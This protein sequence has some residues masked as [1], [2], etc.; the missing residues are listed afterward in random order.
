MKTIGFFIFVRGLLK[1]L[2]S[3]LP[4]FW[5]ILIM[6]FVLF[7]AGK[8]T[9]ARW[10][11]GFSAIW[12]LLISTPFL[13]KSMLAKLENQ[14]PPIQLSIE[15]THQAYSQDSV[16]HILVLGRGYLTD[17][18]ISYS[19]QL[20]YSGLARLV[21]GIRLY[22]LIP[23]SRLIFSGSAGRQPLPLAKIAAMAA[24]ELGID[25]T[26]IYTI[27]KPWN[28]K[29]EAE[30]YIK[31]FGITS[32]LYL[33]TSAAHMPRAIIQFHNA[34]LKPIPAPTNFMLKK[35]SIP[36]SYADYFPGSDNIRFMEIVFNE[37]LGMLWAFLGGD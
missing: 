22:R 31:R 35:N 20:H 2:L 18:R 23:S 8:K 25:S 10:L 4:L 1:S 34:G 26:V 36:S 37:Y 21:E 28:T 3:P 11:L 33:V 17:D 15:N 7:L 27:C 13:P 6:G 14:Y 29:T 30:E 5:L 32:K 19:G 9:V 24:Q 12:I 16:V